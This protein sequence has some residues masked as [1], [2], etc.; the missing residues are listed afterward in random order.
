MYIPFALFLNYASPFPWWFG[1]ALQV[2]GFIFLWS[3]RHTA[4]MYPKWGR[5]Y[6]AFSAVARPIGIL[7]IGWAW[8]EIC[9]YNPPSLPISESLSQLIRLV[10]LLTLLWIIYDEYLRIVAILL[11]VIFTFG[12]LPKQFVGLGVQPFKALCKGEWMV[13]PSP[14]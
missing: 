12:G 14:P 5:G 11:M 3:T 7:M 4:R 10:V 8:V 6:Y 2:V 1:P 9:A 13:M